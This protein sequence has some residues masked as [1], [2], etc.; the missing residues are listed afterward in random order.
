[1]DGRNKRVRGVTSA[2]LALHFVGLIAGCQAGETASHN[3]DVVMSSEDRLR[4]VGNI[5][6][7]FES[8][9]ADFVDPNMLEEGSWLAGTFQASEDPTVL[10]RTAKYVL[11]CP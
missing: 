7:F 11:Y 3:L 9:I 4:Y 1:M 6:G 10:Y 8:L 5:H 2:A